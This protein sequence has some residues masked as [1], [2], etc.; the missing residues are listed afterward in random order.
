MHSGSWPGIKLSE[1]LYFQE[2]LAALMAAP[3]PNQ[4]ALAADGSL[5]DASHIVFY[6]DPDDPLPL[7]LV[8]PNVPIHPFFA[9]APAPGMIIAGSR[10][11]TR[12]TRP[13]TR[14]MDPDNTETY[15]LTR[16]RSATLTT[17]TEAAERS[18]RRARVADSE[19]EVNDDDDDDGDR[20]SEN[21]REEDTDGD[22]QIEEAYQFTKAMGD[23]D[24]E[25]ILYLLLVGLNKI[26]LR[27][28]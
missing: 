1:F 4:C 23:A 3:D 11:S 5:L 27:R 12:A 21:T 17:S 10:R 20:G 14:L 19:D 6:N 18:A 8:A 2:K 15:N 24:R 26:L 16:K 25:V 9:G 7:S 13:S 28:T 22:E